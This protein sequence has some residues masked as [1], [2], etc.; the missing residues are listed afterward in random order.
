L[1][2]ALPATALPRLEPAPQA[3]RIAT[4]A[5]PL[6]PGDFADAALFLSASD[7]AAG[8]ESE[9]AAGLAARFRS[10]VETA[11]AELS[12]IADPY[13]RGEAALT[14]LHDRLL[15]RYLSDQTRMDVLIGS[16]DYNCVSSAVAYMALAKAAGLEV[17][18]AKT[19]DHAFCSV[20]VGDR[21]VDV[22]TTNRYGFD[23]GTKK[24][25]FSD[26]FGKTT[27]FAYVP[28]SNYARRSR[29]GEIGLLSLILQ[30]RIATLELSRRN[31]EA[32]ALAADLLAMKPDDESRQILG[33]RASNLAGRALERGSP[34]EALALAEAIEARYGKLPKLNEARAVAVRNALAD[35]GNR[36]LYAEGFSFMGWAKERY[37]DD[38]AFA[39]FA[40][41]AVNNRSVDLVRA[42]SFELALEFLDAAAGLAPSKDIAVLGENAA[43]AWI[44]SSG[45]TLGF[46]ERL[47]LTDRMRM[48]GRISPARA[49]E[50][51]LA[52][53]GQEANARAA[54]D[55]SRGWLDAAGAFD[56]GLGFLS[57]DPGLLRGKL[58]CLGN[59][60]GATLNRFAA[61][62]NARKLVEAREILTEGIALYP[63]GERLKAQL[64]Q[65][66]KAIASQ[67]AAGQPSS[68]PAAR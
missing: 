38:P 64:V 30:N 23:P 49:A 14:L 58:Q 11:A 1:P 50:A 16:G 8:L 17:S 55:K 27:G 42:G 35:F 2:F 39:G 45:K 21:S 19:P 65:V 48:E 54:A 31:G 47:A 53:C 25:A 40:K 56:Q 66:D 33:E 59:F 5:E 29:I 18:G 26:S 51:F 60:E 22:E 34:L 67:A 37:G 68:K 4:L 20:I 9:A 15:K 57:G 6:A 32:F 46:A 52:V 7:P 28:P 44:D 43:L 13:E 63:G 36:G 62:F 41:A 10:F 3:S 61:L 24:S 12:A